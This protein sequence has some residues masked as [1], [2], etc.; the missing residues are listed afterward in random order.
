[1][2]NMFPTEPMICCSKCSTWRHVKC[3]GHYKHWLSGNS[4]P[5]DSVTDPLCDRCF[6]EKDILKNAGVHAITRIENQRIGHLRRCN[7]TNAV[8][9]QQAFSKHFQSKWPLGSVL[10]ANFSG[11]TRSVQ[12]RHKKAEALWEEMISKIDST[13][14]QRVRD[15]VRALERLLQSV[16]DAGNFLSC[17]ITS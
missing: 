9:R 16:E 8:I 15:K 2:A 14:K 11:H 3:G 6:L 13:K 7:A 12:T 4:V 1:V 17:I 10:P 5:F